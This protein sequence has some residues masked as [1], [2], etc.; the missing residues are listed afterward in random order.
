MLQKCSNTVDCCECLIMFWILIVTPNWVNTIGFR[1]CNYIDIYNPWQP[2]FLPVL[3]NVF[4][5]LC[6]ISPP[7][8]TQSWWIDPPLKL[9]P[10]SKRSSCVF[11]NCSLFLAIPCDTVYTLVWWLLTMCLFAQHPVFGYFFSVRPDLSH[12]R[13]F[14]F[15]GRNSTP[16]PAWI[17]FA[18]PLTC[19]LDTVWLYSVW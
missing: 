5:M 17:F 11:H 8:G 15:I 2:P 7:S 1:K 10:A 4:F 14:F 18:I 12:P 19:Y 6:L 13:I 9:L 16:L 3:K